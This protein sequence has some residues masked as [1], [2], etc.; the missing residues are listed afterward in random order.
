M[1]RVLVAAQSSVVRAG[2]ESLVR[3]SSALELA[4]ALDWSRMNSDQFPADV[5]LLDA[6]ELSNERFA[7]LVGDVSQKVVILLAAR[8]L[9]RQA[10]RYARAFAV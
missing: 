4:G 3:S 10:R 5:V 1:I 8:I 2:L 6:G 7:S 9:G